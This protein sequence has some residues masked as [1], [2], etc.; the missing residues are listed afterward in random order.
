MHAII[1]RW[2]ADWFI[3]V[4]SSSGVE[5]TFTRGMDAANFKQEACTEFTEWSYWKVMIDVPRDPEDQIIAAAQKSYVR[6]F[7]CARKRHAVR[8]DKGLLRK[9][10]PGSE[11]AFLKQRR[12]TTLSQRDA[13]ARPIQVEIDSMDTSGHWTAAHEK[14][15][16]FARSKRQKK[17]V[18][19][20]QDGLLVSREM[21]A[22]LQELA[23]GEVVAAQDTSRAFKG[24]SKLRNLFKNGCTQC[25]FA[26]L[27][28][29]DRADKRASNEMRNLSRACGGTGPS[30]VDLVGLKCYLDPS[31]RMTAVHHLHKWGLLET[32]HVHLADVLVVQDPGRTQPHLSWSSG[33]PHQPSTP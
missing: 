20:A 22:D 17:L 2:F 25:W 30:Y 21:T 24:S 32:G 1:S 3:F 27:P 11:A 23:D 14:E 31:L 28:L 15:A 10:R 6:M 16:N 5:Q 18:K 19:A 12:S 4:V 9:S 13:L 26:P 8:A 29:Q 7:G 33:S